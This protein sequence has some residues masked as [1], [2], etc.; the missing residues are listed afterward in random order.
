MARGL[1]LF[2]A[3][4]D[5]GVETI[6]VFPYAGYRALAG[7]SRLPKKTT[8][9]GIK[10]RIR[11]LRERGIDEPHL[12]MWSHDGLDALLAALIALGPRRAVGHEGPGCDES[13]IW[14]PVV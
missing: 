14:L 8:A 5:A 12:E 4:T 9:A 11:L 7:T 6:E 13:K 2:R 10:D 3:L 1:E